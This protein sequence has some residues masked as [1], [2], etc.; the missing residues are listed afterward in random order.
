MRQGFYYKMQQFY[1]K[2]QQLLQN[3]TFIQIATVHCVLTLAICFSKDYDKVY[4][5]T[6]RNKL[7]NNLQLLKK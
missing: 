4:Y 7:P 3:T 5:Q 1:Y 2:M 6:F